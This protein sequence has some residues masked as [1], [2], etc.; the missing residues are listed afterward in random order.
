MQ[1]WVL[2][3][4]RVLVLGL[5]VTPCIWRVGAASAALVLG[6]GNADEKPT[7]VSATL[8][9]DKFIIRVR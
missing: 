6:A 1:P 7:H 4:V 5:H 3:W 9:L 2:G 8:I